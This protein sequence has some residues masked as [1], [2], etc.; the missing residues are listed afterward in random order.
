VPDGSPLRPRLEVA[1]RDALRAGDA[2]ARSALRS[3][4]AAI[5]N[6]TAVPPSHPPAAPAAAGSVH[7][8]G[9]VAGLGA[10]EAERRRLTEADLEDLVRAEVA[11]REA[12][13]HDYDQAGQPGHAARLRREA[14]VLLAVLGA[15]AS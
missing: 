7:I 3:A 5:D 13:A 12:A 9:A 4:L 14:A 11:E 10:G 6:A 15:D 8:A 1:L 2:V